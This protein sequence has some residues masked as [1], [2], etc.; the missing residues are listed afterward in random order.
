MA[1]QGEI[2][3]QVTD[4]RSKLVKSTC[5]ALVKL[6]RAAKR[7]FQPLADHILPSVVKVASNSSAA[8]RTPGIA[9]F[10]AISQHARYNLQAVHRLYTQIKIRE[11]PLFS[12]ALCTHTHDTFTNHVVLL[13]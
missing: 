4:L 11:F 13:A 3:A 7:D 10:H 1:R 5:E 6:V 12:L 8:F 9:C 2:G